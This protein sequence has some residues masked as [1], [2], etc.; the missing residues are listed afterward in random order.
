MLAPESVANA[1]TGIYCGLLHSVKFSNET[2]KNIL[3]IKKKLT[4]K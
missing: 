4:I 1:R 3:E 2:I